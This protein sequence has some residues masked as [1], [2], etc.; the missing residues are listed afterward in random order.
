MIH[1]IRSWT[2]IWKSWK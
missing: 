1:P 2:W